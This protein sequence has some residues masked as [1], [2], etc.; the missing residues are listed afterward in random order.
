MEESSKEIQEPSKTQ[1]YRLTSEERACLE[2]CALSVKNI[3]PFI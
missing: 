1:P 2:F 3:I